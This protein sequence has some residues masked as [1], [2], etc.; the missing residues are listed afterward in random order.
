MSHGQRFSVIQRHHGSGS[1]IEG[2]FEPLQQLAVSIRIGSGGGEAAFGFRFVGCH[3]ADGDGRTS[4]GPRLNMK[5]PIGVQPRQPAQHFF[6]RLEPIAGPELVGGGLNFSNI[7]AGPA[8]EEILAAKPIVD[9][10]T[11]TL[12][13]VR[14]EIITDPVVKAMQGVV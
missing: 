6:F 7:S 13:G 3:H 9:R 5:D 11:N 12:F 1:D 8:G 4:R 2:A 10:A 14:A